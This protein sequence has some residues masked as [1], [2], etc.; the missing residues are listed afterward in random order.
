[1]PSGIKNL[2]ELIANVQ[3]YPRVKRQQGTI[4]FF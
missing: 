3:G 4:G 1:M 2:S